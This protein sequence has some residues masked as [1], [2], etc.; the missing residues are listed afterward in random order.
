MSDHGVE[1]DIS[2]MPF[3][4]LDDGENRPV[5]HIQGEDGEEQKFAPEEVSAMVLQKCKTIA[6]KHLGVP[7]DKAVITVPA[8]FN[9]AQRNATKAAG[10]EL[11]GNPGEGCGLRL[12][13]SSLQCV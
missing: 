9:D 2:S 8:Y 1:K 7:V 13:V 12:S 11:R 5:I 4:V 6:E 10:D 3:S